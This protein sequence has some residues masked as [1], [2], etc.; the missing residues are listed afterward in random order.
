MRKNLEN[1]VHD[2]VKKTE[3][4]PGLN[5]SLAVR[6]E[7]AISFLENSGNLKKKSVKFFIW[8]FGAYAPGFF[9]NY[10][11]ILFWFTLH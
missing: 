9:A 11:K 3:N 2:S 7:I 5:T 6:V 1:F 8:R 4:M 10:D